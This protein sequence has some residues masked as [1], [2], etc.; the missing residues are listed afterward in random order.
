MSLSSSPILG[1]SAIGPRLLCDLVS[2][3]FASGPGPQEK[4]AGFLALALQRAQVGLE[5]GPLLRAGGLRLRDAS[6]HEVHAPPSLLHLEPCLELRDHLGQSTPVPFLDEE[7]GEGA[8][9]GVAR[10]VWHEAL[11]RRLG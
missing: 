10:Q 4:L 1:S 7:G 2:R 6:R 9:L 8:A 3:G 5:L 11:R